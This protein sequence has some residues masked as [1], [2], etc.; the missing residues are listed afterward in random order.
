M[1][2][3]ILTTLIIS[4]Y[5]LYAAAL[6]VQAD[7]TQFTCQT[8]TVNFT[9]DC[10]F[11]GQVWVPAAPPAGISYSNAPSTTAPYWDVVEGK[12]SLDIDVNDLGNAGSW[13][14]N[15]LVISSDSVCA[16]PITDNAII[17]MT[18]DCLG[19]PNNDCP[20]A[21]PVAVDFG[22]CSYL[23]FDTNNTSFS[24]VT[25]SCHNFSWVDLW[26]SFTANATSITLEYSSNPGILAFYTIFSACPSNGGS[27]LSCGQILNF[28]GT[29]GSLTLTVP[30]VDQQY[31]LQMSFNPTENGTDQSFCLHSATVPAPCPAQITISDAGPNIPNAS[32]TVSDH[33]KTSGSAVVTTP[34]IVYDAAAYVLLDA[35]FECFAD[36]EIKLDGCMP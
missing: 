33:I 15:F 12:I 5:W 19:P 18:Y 11:T 13:N 32:Y 24:G 6:S 2:R 36:F 7:V 4:S 25:T 30:V 28:S 34:G 8:T 23:N 26:Y 17:S 9:F 20:A 29:P 16:M 3:F 10:G 31:Y 27:E 14:I 22:S 21:T 35:G 1:I